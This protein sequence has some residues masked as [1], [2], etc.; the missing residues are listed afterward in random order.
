M[1]AAF[2]RAYNKDSAKLPYSVSS[3]AIKKTT[4]AII[5]NNPYEEEE[6]DSTPE[7][8]DDIMKDAMIKVI[9]INCTYTLYELIE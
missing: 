5:D 4:S 8:D 1:K 6:V 7:D 3:A 2:T 9:W